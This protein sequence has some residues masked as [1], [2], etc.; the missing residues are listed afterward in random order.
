MRL[1]IKGI[2]GIFK[3][4]NILILL[5]EANIMKSLL[6]ADHGVGY[7]NIDFDDVEPYNLYWLIKD[8][9]KLNVT[10]TFGD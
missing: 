3:V 7:M 5:E 4:N 9:T 2:D 10:I 6:K 1:T 8:I